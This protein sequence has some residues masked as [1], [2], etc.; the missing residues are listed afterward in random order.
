MRWTRGAS[1]ASNLPGAPRPPWPACAR[2]PTLLPPATPALHPYA[3][4][5]VLRHGASTAQRDR[6]FVVQWS[7]LFGVV[8]RAGTPVSVC[9]MCLARSPAIQAARCTGCASCGGIRLAGFTA[10]VSSRGSRPISHVG[11]VP[12]LRFQEM[13]CPPRL[14]NT[15]GSVP[16]VD[17]VF[18]C[19]TRGL[20]MC[21]TST[22][23]VFTLLSPAVTRSCGRGEESGERDVRRARCSQRAVFSS[24]TANSCAWSVGRPTR[25]AADLSGCRVLS[26]SCIE[27]FYICGLPGS[28]RGICAIWSLHQANR[29]ARRGVTHPV[30]LLARGGRLILPRLQPALP[31]RGNI[32]PA[33]VH[34]L[35]YA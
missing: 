6:V 19:A 1:C 15:C 3:G 17:R 18:P 30:W 20:G 23:H 34:R 4:R 9:R 33:N 25:A 32:R 21:R 29:L 11:Q 35:W 5:G 12:A 2:L 27:T 7:S 22:S 13:V 31:V 28:G 24:L 10:R 16:L 26:A 8:S 14:C